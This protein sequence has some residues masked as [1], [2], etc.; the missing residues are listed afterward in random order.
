V[1]ELS[2][3]ERTSLAPVI[4]DEIR[5][6]AHAHGSWLPLD[7]ARHIEKQVIRPALADRDAQLAAVEALPD[8]WEHQRCCEWGCEGDMADD[9]SALHPDPSETP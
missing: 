6:F 2:A 3:E 9:R 8:E 7:L 1:S 4:A 5:M